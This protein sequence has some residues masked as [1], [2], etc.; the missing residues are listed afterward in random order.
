M[1]DQERWSAPEPTLAGRP[2]AQVRGVL[3]DRVV[4]ST[5]LDPFLSLRALAG[6]SGLSVRKLRDYLDD[7]AHPLPCYRC[8][9]K[10]VVRRSEF[11]VWMTAYRRV[12]RANV[13]EIVNGVLRFLPR[14]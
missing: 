8:G 3:A 12:G 11:D 14:R 6:Y 2:V 1:T 7:P 4:V 13:D 9:G 5:P 10:I